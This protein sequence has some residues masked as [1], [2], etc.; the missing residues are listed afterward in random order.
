MRNGKSYYCT[1]LSPHFTV[2]RIVTYF[3]SYIVILTPRFTPPS[4]NSHSCSPTPKIKSSQ[5]SPVYKVTNV[6]WIKGNTTQRPEV[7]GL[8]MIAP[9]F[10]NEGWRIINLEHSK[11]N[12]KSNFWTGQHPTKEQ[13]ICSD[14]F[15]GIIKKD[16]EMVP[17]SVRSISSIASRISVYNRIS[18]NQVSAGSQL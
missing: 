8:K 9:S 6:G 14:Y 7:P 17:V 13:R 10:N 16:I 5:L 11:C 18:T 1:A 4:R 2:R 15:F 3:T 12:I